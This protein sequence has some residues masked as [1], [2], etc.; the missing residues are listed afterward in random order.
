MKKTHFKW[1][2][3]Y[4][5][6]WIWNE[7]RSF[8]ASNKLHNVLFYWNVKNSSTSQ[9]FHSPE[10]E[11]LFTKTYLVYYI[12]Y[13]INIVTQKRSESAKPITLKIIRG[14]HRWG[15][16]SS[17]QF[18]LS[19]NPLPTQPLVYIVQID[20]QQKRFNKLLFKWSSFFLISSLNYFEPYQPK[21]VTIDSSIPCIYSSGKNVKKILRASKKGWIFKLF[22][23][24][25]SPYI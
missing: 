18:A 14:I 12:I 8:N 17:L 23:F 16:L 19:M 2:T 10:T 24:L 9:I 20:K 15:F 6:S 21:Y 7:W 11:L 13:V 3:S 1:A 5:Q 22:L 25:F 4:L